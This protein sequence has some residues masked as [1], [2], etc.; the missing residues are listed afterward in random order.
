M[1]HRKLL[2]SFVPGMEAAVIALLLV[3]ARQFERLAR[4]WLIP[5]AMSTV[6]S[7]CPWGL[8]WR[9]VAWHAT[10]GGG[11]AP[12]VALREWGALR[13]RR[14]TTLHPLLDRTNNRRVGISQSGLPLNDHLAR[15]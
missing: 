13:A 5:V 12:L 11:A 9:Q 10:V 14:P 15:F 3:L 2:T 7:Q 1:N 6:V 8:R 4:R